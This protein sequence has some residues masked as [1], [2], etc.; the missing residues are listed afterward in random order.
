M[1][2]PASIAAARIDL[3][4]DLEIHRDDRRAQ[5]RREV[6]GALVEVPDV[7]G[8]DAAAFGAEIDRLA[9]AA[10]HLAGA[11]EDAAA[12]VGTVLRNGEEGAHHPGD[13]AERDPLAQES[14]EEEAAV[15]QAER[16]EDEEVERGRVVR[17]VDRL[18][19]DGR[20]PALAVA[21][22]S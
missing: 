9:R 11:P 14:A 8:R 19:A 18:R 13:D 10:Q 6:E 3:A 17:D 16:D 20:P 4:R 2:R 22:A 12:F 15:R 21:T 1:P 7:A 5:H